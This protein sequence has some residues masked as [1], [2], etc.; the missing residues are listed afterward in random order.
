M[1]TASLASGRLRRNLNNSEFVFV[2]LSDSLVDCTPNEEPNVPPLFLRLD[3]CYDGPDDMAR[4][5]R[6]QLNEPP[7][8][9]R[10]CHRVTRGVC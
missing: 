1:A 10:Q 9:W 7:Q 8:L 4:E 5:G 2:E 6:P 3:E